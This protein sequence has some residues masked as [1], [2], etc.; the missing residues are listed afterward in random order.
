MS[1]VELKFSQNVI[2]R[3]DPTW[4]FPATLLHVTIAVEKG[5]KHHSTAFFGELREEMLKVGSW[6]QLSTQSLEWNVGWQKTN[7]YF[8]PTI[9]T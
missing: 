8:D 1:R 9:Q 3:V 4:R 5:Q 7:F 6:I 2:P